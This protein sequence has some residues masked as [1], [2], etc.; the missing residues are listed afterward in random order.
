[1]LQEES[2]AQ[3][4]CNAAGG[5]TASDETALRRTRGPAPAGRAE[6]LGGGLLRAPVGPVLARPKVGPP[7]PALP[8]TRAL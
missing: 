7:A 3:V 2:T 8:D 6:Q 4:A 5:V 1:M